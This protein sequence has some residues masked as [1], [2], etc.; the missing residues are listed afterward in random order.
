[1][2]MQFFSASWGSLLSGLLMIVTNNVDVL[3]TVSFIP[4]LW[5]HEFWTEKSINNLVMDNIDGE[6]YGRFEFITLCIIY[7]PWLY[8]WRGLV[9]DVEKYQQLGNSE[10]LQLII[11][12]K[13][14]LECQVPTTNYF[15]FFRVLSLLHFLLLRQNYK[16][17]WEYII[18]PFLT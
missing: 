5:G 16:R 11:S 1:M 9:Q 14:L 6:S 2:V 10:S 3:G 4:K 13:L 12:W 8:G 18:L 17:L 15:S 7:L